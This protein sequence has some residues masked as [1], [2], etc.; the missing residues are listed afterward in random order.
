MASSLSLRLGEGRWRIDLHSDYTSLG[1]PETISFQS[2]KEKEVCVEKKAPAE[3]CKGVLV[4][5]EQG[6][7]VH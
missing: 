3:P 2:P 6:S 7:W 5:S 1:P 4:L